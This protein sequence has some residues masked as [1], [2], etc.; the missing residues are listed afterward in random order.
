MGRQNAKQWCEKDAEMIAQ[1]RDHSGM[2]DAAIQL[3]PDQ[4]PA[5]VLLQLAM[6]NIRQ[7]PIIPVSCPVGECECNGRAEGAIR[8]VQE[9]VRALRH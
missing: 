8:R 7:A 6:Q 1:D 2:K 3:K 4:E 5:I 9:K